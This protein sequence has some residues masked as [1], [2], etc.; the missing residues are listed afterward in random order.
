MDVSRKSA[1]MFFKL[2]SW[3]QVLLSYLLDGCFFRSRGGGGPHEGC[4]AQTSQREAVGWFIGP[5]RPGL[6]TDNLDR[7]GILEKHFGTRH[8]RHHVWPFCDVTTLSR[9]STSSCT[10]CLRVCDLV[11]LKFYKS[12]FQVFQNNDLLSFS[13]LM[14]K[15]A[16][17]YQISPFCSSVGNKFDLL[18]SAF[19]K[20]WKSWK[21]AW[22][23]I[24]ESSV[25]MRV[26]RLFLFHCA[27][28]LTPCVLL[29]C[30]AAHWTAKSV[31]WLSK[32][33]LKNSRQSQFL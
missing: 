4:E 20:S 14:N 15:F 7:I 29:S 23:K 1:V 21:V 28:W 30:T 12:S 13:G 16:L 25:K 9:P 11:H 6:K 8:P 19:W 27:T 26:S 32:Q 22:S 33:K 18:G 3:N 5:G 24:L 17:A 31:T 2:F 10:S